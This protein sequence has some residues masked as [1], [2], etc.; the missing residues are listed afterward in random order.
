MNEWGLIVMTFFLTMYA[1]RLWYLINAYQDDYWIKEHNVTEDPGSWFAWHMRG[2]HRWDV[3]SH[4]EAFSCWVMAKM[5]SP[6]EFKVWCNLAMVLRYIGNIKESDEALREAQTCI[7]KGQE[8][9]SEKLIREIRANK[10][11][12]M[13]ILT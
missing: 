2:I 13:P 4:H 9:E 3:G 10:R 5:I 8:V 1:V 11:G 7:L 12:H 6:K